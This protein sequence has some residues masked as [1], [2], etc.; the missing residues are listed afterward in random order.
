[1]KTGTTYL[2]Y[3]NI[4]GF[5]DRWSVAAREAIEEI[6]ALVDP[7]A[8]CVDVKIPLVDGCR[9]QIMPKSDIKKLRLENSD[10]IYHEV[11]QIADSLLDYV[12]KSLSDKKFYGN[13]AFIY[14]VPVPMF[15]DLGLKDKWATPA[16]IGGRYRFADGAPHISFHFALASPIALKGVG[17]PGMTIEQSEHELFKTLVMHEYLHIFD[18]PKRYSKNA[19]DEENN[20]CAHCSDP[21]CIM[22]FYDPVNKTLSRLKRGYPVCDDCKAQI[23]ELR[24]IRRAL[25]RYDNNGLDSSVRR[26]KGK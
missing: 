9:S 1:M 25:V 19:A 24:T 21:D 6:D 20:E 13:D 3:D 11:V 2:L 4:K 16:G 26:G 12:S 15:K 17:L 18:I 23:E 5:A 14:L 7:T 22:S 10:I 8:R